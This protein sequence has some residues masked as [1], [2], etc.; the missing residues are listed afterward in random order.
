MPLTPLFCPDS[1]VSGNRNALF[2]F[3]FGDF[4]TRKRQATSFNSSLFAHFH[5]ST[6]SIFCFIVES[7][8]IKMFRSSMRSITGKFII[9]HG[10][11][12][13]ADYSATVPPSFRASL[14]SLFSSFFRLAF[15]CLALRSACSFSFLAAAASSLMRFSSRDRR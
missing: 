15:S 13:V 2:V 11:L 8:A 3:F 6:I 14:A 9:L 1:F 4:H 12:L 10:R 7:N 5:A